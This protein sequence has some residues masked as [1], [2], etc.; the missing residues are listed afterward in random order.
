MQRLT[1]KAL[2][3]QK[4]A[5]TQVSYDCGL[6]VASTAVTACK[7]AF[8]DLSQVSVMVLGAGETAELTLHYLVSK[9]VRRVTVANRTVERAEQLAR[10]T[11]GTAL[12][13]AAFPSRLADVDMIIC[14]TSSPEPVL[15]RAMVDEAMSL[16]GHRPMLVVDIAVP[17][18]VEPTVAEI[19]GVQLLNIDALCGTAMA[20]QEQ[21]Q[22]KLIAA[23][24]IISGEAR[25]FGKWL[26]CRRAIAVVASL[27][28]QIDTLREEIAAAI[29][30]E[31]GVEDSDARDMVEAQTRELVRGILRES[32]G[33]MQTFTGG[34]DAPHQM[35]MV[36]RMLELEA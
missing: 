6:S 21:R 36:R 16:R 11:G 30:T 26:S 22:A 7:R 23:D 9:G 2:A 31:L 3:A 13:L 35:A 29:V 14:C 17:R 18:D 27:R 4:R 25:E 34:G 12:P 10:L 24:E 20:T 1:E 19:P 15:T 33:A 32:L 8:D 28:Q 5:R